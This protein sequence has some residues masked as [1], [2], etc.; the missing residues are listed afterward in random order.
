M[1]PVEDLGADIVE[2]IR[3]IKAK[4]GPDLNRLGQLETDTGAARTRA[5]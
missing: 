5:R 1:G 4:G 3:R 2:G